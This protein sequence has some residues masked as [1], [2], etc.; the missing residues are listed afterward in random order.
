LTAAITWPILPDLIDSWTTPQALELITTVGPPDCAT[1]ALG[2][3]PILTAPVQI[4]EVL[5]KSPILARI[6]NRC[7]Q[8]SI[9]FGR[10]RILVTTN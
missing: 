8:I 4:F 7:P 10:R 2:F 9:L 6:Y 1:I 5:L 3:A